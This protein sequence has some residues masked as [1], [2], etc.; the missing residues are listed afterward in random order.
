V[1]NNL[2]IISS[3][4]KLQSRNVKDEQAQAI[5]NDSQNRVRS[6][7]LIHEKLYQSENLAEID[8]AGYARSLAINLFRS[9]G[10]SEEVV[11]LRLDVENVLLGV[12]TA[13]PC[14]L[15]LNELVSNSLKYAFPSNRKGEILIHL[16]KDAG[17][18]YTLVVGDTGVGIPKTWIT[19]I[20]NRWACSWSILCQSNWKET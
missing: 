16:H 1:K 14:G 10:I 6:M 15:I 9:Y 12:D 8:F 7:A 4:L 18:K 19:G 13:I 2:Q 11:T 5:F 3:L 20:R 17:D